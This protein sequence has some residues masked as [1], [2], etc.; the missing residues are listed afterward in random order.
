MRAAGDV[1]HRYPRTADVLLWSMLVQARTTKGTRFMTKFVVALFVALTAVVLGAAPDITGLWEVDVEFDDNSI[2]GGGVD[3]LFQQHESGRLSGRCMDS[4]VTM[5]QI[6]EQNVSWRFEKA[7]NTLTFNGSVNE[8]GT[9]ITG[10]F[11]MNDK[12]GRFVASPHV[13]SR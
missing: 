10:T 12:R 2:S 11:T 7:G 6:K 13:S 5:G 4:Y 1:D 9:S 3:C 8:K